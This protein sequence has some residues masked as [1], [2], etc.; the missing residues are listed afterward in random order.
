MARHPVTSPLLARRTAR[1]NGRRAAAV[2]VALVLALAACGGK[3]ADDEGGSTNRK[4]GGATDAIGTEDVESGLA[5]AGKPVRGGTIKYGVAAESTGGFCLPEAQLAISGEVVVRALYDTLTVPN[6]KGEY[7]PYLAKTITHNADHTQ[8]DITVRSGV[9]FS[10]GSKLTAQVVKNN[11]DAYRGK[12]PTRK[13]LLFPFVFDNI[14]NVTVTGPLTVRVAMKKPWASFP[15]FLYGSSRVG[16]VGQAQLDD[17]KTCDRKLVGT[18]PFQ[19]VSWQPNVVLKA[20]RNPHYWQKAPD[21]KPYPYADALEIRPMPEGDIRMN[22]LLGGDINVM[23][24]DE[25]DVMSQLI[26]DSNDGKVN[27]LVSEGQAEV[28]HLLLN[29]ARAPFDD[30]RIRRAAAMAVDRDQMIELLYDGLPPKANGPFPKG[31]IGYL[32]D[33]GFPG[34]DLAAAKRL[35]AA[36]K[37]DK[38]SAPSFTLTVNPGSDG[39]RYGELVQQQ[40]A[41]AGF[42]V[43]I[44]PED[45]AKQINDAI[46]G[47]FQALQWRNHPGEDPDTQYVWWYSTSPV[48]FGRIKDPK[49]D[50]LLDEGRAEGD[51]TK[52]KQIYEDL[53][54]EFAAKVWNVWVAFAPWAVAESPDVHGIIG[55]DLPDGSK[56][57]GSLSTAHSLLG[58]WIAP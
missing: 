30:E 45:E 29:S 51:Q 34:H 31:T 52:R 17:T 41:K 46:A 5:D 23:H 28:Q 6:D 13:P 56:P 57:S 54:R 1:R 55:P 15:A 38:G 9:L 32:A 43:R 11:L 48:N 35:V 44:A 7:V 10:D 33:P 20:K 14:E 19:L 27:L 2:G 24:T 18:G 21:G 36:Y 37:A 22:S 39:S 42:S 12:Y 26:S 16:I 47:Q 49:I 40:L 8:W 53:N 25:A 50:Q 58:L 3:K 4:G